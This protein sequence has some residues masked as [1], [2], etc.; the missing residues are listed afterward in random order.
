MLEFLLGA[1]ICLISVYLGYGMGK[2]DLPSV[3]FLRKMKRVIR[4]EDQE[5]QVLDQAYRPVR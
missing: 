5:A 3:P 4:T 1:C 2:G